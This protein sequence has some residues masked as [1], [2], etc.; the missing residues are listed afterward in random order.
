MVH[1]LSRSD[2]DG[3][4]TCSALQ[5]A[6]FWACGMKRNGPW[7]PYRLWLLAYRLHGLALGIVRSMTALTLDSGNH[8][9]QRQ[10]PF[11]GC[12]RRVAAEAAQLIVGSHTAP[13]SIEGFGQL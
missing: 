10:S 7:P 3:L 2:F 13:C 5:A 12:I 9:V 11:L 8:F 1:S 6:R 4:R